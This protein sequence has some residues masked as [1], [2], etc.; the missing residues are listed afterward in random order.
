M[1]IVEDEHGTYLQPDW[2]LGFRVTTYP[3]TVHAVPAHARK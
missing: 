3:M 2:P 1:L